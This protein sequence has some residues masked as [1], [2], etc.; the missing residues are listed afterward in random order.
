MFPELLDPAAAPRRA[1][2]ARRRARR[3]EA[4]ERGVPRLCLRARLL[5]RDDSVDR[6]HGAPL[7]RRAVARR[8]PRARA[9]RRDLRGAFRRAWGFSTRWAAPRSAA[10]V[11]ATFGAAWV[12]SGVLSHERL[13]LRRLSVGAP[14]ESRSRTS[15]SCSA[16]PRS[17]AFSVVVSRGLAL[18][19]ALFVALTRPARN[20]R[21][22]WLTGRG[23]R[24]RDRGSGRAAAG[25]AR[26]GEFLR[27]GVVQPN[28]PQDLRWEA[29]TAER[30]FADLEDQ[31]R[32]LCR[33]GRPV[34][35]LWPESASPYAWS[36]AP[37]FRDRVVALCR[38]LDIAILLSTVWSDAP[39][40]PG[41]PV[42]QRRAPRDEGRPRARR[43][44]SSSGSCL[45]ASTCRSP[46]FSG[47]VRPISRAVPSAFTP[48]AGAALAAARHLEAR[49]R[50][51]LRSR[52]PLDRARGDARGSG[53]P[54]HAHERRVVRARGRAAAALAVGRRARDR[55]GPSARAR[56]D[57]GDQRSRGR[58]RA[59]FS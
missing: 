41:R 36:F 21:L 12:V 22:A 54:V 32:G 15:R 38:E 27:V 43:L 48:G 24:R 42:L 13:D 58:K 18:N 45:S 33:H 2:P 25:R 29:G 35:V 26:S 46:A 52:L 34:L 7:R 17:A 50:R 8:G 30:L 44:T 23:A 40:D 51:V 9:R 14:R 31:T 39:D 57:H 11:V 16:R 19:A 28:V 37:A 56:G 59:A 55:D 47:V 3:G 49:R 1:D 20:Q 53:R 5:D 6:V 4:E 10:G